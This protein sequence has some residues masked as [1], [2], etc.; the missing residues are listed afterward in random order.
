L[1]EE[2]QLVTQPTDARDGTRQR[3]TIPVAA[4]I[5]LVVVL[6]DLLVGSRA[7]LIGLL[8]A[9]P[10]FTGLRASPAVALGTGGTAIAIAAGSVAW[11][12]TW[13]NWSYWV[14]LTVVTLAALFGWRMAVDRA[15][16]RSDAARKQILVELSHLGHG[17]AETATMAAGFCELLVPDVCELAVI[18]LL[19]DGELRRIAGAFSGEP[20]VLAAVVRRPP[21]QAPLA[22]SAAAARTAEVQ[23]L[24]HIDAAW[25]RQVATDDEDLA[26]LERLEL[27]S[28]VV[29]P[30]I[31]RNHPIGTLVYGSRSAARSLTADD[32][33][34]F[35]RLV[36]GRVALA[37][38]NA[39]LADELRRTGQQLQAILANADIAVMVRA[40]GGELIYANQSAAELLD[41]P[42]AAAIADAT[43][44]QL[45]ERFDVYDEAGASVALTDLP[46]ARLLAGE[47]DPKPML[48]RS[49]VRRTGQERWL[50]NRATAIRGAD[51][52]VEM[53]VNLIEDFTDTKRNEIAQR[54]LANAARVVNAAGE[55]EPALQAIADAAVPGLADWAG[56]DLLDSR[57]RIRTVA[58]AHRSAE[59]VQLGWR[60]RTDWPVDFNEPAG[61]AEVIRSGRSELSSEITDEMLIAAARDDEHL[62]VL[63]T[64]GLNSTMVVPIRAGDTA[65]GALSFVSST[66]R[67][68]DQ[69]DLRLAEDLGH[70]VGILIANAQLQAERVSIAHTLQAGLLPGR[71]PDVSGWTVQA[72]YRAAGQANEV[73][74]DFYDIV[75]FADGWSAI[76]GDVVG[77]GAE[78]AVLTALARHTLAAIIESTSDPVNALTV[79]NRRLRERGGE[80]FASLCTIAVI[81]IRRDRAQILSAG[82]PRPLLIRG[83]TV[84][85]I[86]TPGVLL[87][88]IDDAAITS[89]TIDLITGDKLLLYTD[90]VTDAIGANERFGD[91]RLLKTV[92]TLA[93]DDANDL[94][95]ELLTAI[96]TFSVG[97]QSDDIAI[98]ALHRTADA[99]PALAA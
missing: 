29:V 80:G 38:D 25:L 62:R 12:D 81:T 21:S 40:A 19:V 59:H 13:G 72:A 71:L 91:R 2:S 3:A 54:L 52:R 22:G 20:G 61:L 11:N 37:L 26:L 30:L 51:G 16:L 83:D 42:D 87:G 97:E 56:V 84:T 32:T 57:R 34:G 49:V 53:A 41:L 92:A 15:R 36:A 75:P 96:D 58:I 5:M 79:L 65:L 82:H 67:R 74:G 98:L 39:R 55:L 68:F 50:L 28:A 85:P 86:G 76:V 35:L 93:H 77:K 31:A 43:S 99:Q 60:L 24:P 46:G 89:A 23:R 1:L 33:V 48:V 17:G 90:G 94:A 95:A 10:L 44:A 66:S 69:R 88:V 18:D 14:P 27:D 6:A 78:A 63:R 4:A 73:G 8:S 45:M 64:V 70:Q 47:A 7:V 9:A